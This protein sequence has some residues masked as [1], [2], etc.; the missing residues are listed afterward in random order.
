MRSAE[1]IKRILEE[2]TLPFKPARKDYLIGC[3]GAGFIMK[4]CHLVAYQNAGF[5]PQFPI[6]KMPCRKA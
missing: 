5:T 6:Q 3:I 4:D 2:A 1:E